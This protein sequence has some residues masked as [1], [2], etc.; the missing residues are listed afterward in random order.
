[1][2]SAIIL[3]TMLSIFAIGAA[4]MAYKQEKSQCN[5]SKIVTINTSDLQNNLNRCIDNLLLKESDIIKISRKGSID[6]VMISIDEYEKLAS[7]ANIK[8]NL[9]S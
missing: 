8:T 4:Y 3:I 6:A 7:V 5:N 9:S 1:M 2:N